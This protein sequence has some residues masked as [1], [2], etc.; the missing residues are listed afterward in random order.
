MSN[1]Q[2]V[3]LSILKD[4]HILMQTSRS[5]ANRTTNLK[6]IFACTALAE[7][8]RAYFKLLDMAVESDNPTILGEAIFYL[9]NLTD[10]DTNGD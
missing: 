8:L 6:A 1:D 3:T 7:I 4:A 10:G 9:H 5:Q 2:D